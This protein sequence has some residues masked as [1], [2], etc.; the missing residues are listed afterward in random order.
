[1]D[2]I[3]RQRFGIARIS[4]EDFGLGSALT[5]HRA[6]LHLSKQDL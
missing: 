6:A 1:M 3:E 4:G 5:K 2:M